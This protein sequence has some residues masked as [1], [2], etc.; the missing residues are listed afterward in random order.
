MLVCGCEANEE[1]PVAPAP[2][3]I[4]SGCVEFGPETCIVEGPKQLSIWLD[5]HPATPLLVRIDGKAVA[6]TGRVIQGGVRLAVEVPRGAEAVRVETPAQTWSPEVTIAFEWRARPPID[7]LSPKELAAFAKENSGWAKLRAL[8]RLRQMSEG[9]PSGL[10][11]GEAELALARELGAVHHQARALAQRAHTFTEIAPDHRQARDALDALD[12]LTEVSPFAA[13]RWQYHNALLARR[14]GDLGAAIA[15]FEKA[16]TLSE[17]LNFGVAD[18][19]ELLANTLAELGRVEEARDLLRQLETD[20]WEKGTGCLEWLRIANNLAWGQLVLGAAGHDHDDP[21][22]LLLAALE[23]VDSCPHPRREAALLLDLALA[24]LEYGRP[25]EA[26]GWLAHVG[27]V[28]ASLRGWIEITESAAAHERRDAWSQPPLLLRP[29][30]T[31]DFELS[32]NQSV[33]RGDLLAG[34]GFDA[35]A[36]EAYLTS[37]HQLSAT[38]EQVGTNK[39]GELYLAGRSA[40]LEGLVEALLRMNRHAEASCAVRLAR[41]R[42]FARLDRNARLSVATADERVRWERNVV[43]IAK[44]RRAIA[45]EQAGLWELSEADQVQ[46]AGKLSAQTQRTQEDLD[47]AIRGLGLEPNA[48]SC[49][50]LRPPSP[51]EVIL[52]AFASRVF[53]VSESKIQVSPRVDLSSLQNLADASRITL[54]EAGSAAGRPLHLARWRHAKSLIDLAPVS[55]SLDLPPRTVS[56]KAARTALVL[57]DPHDD[58]PEARTEADAVGRIL[59]AEGWKVI[60]LRGSDATQSSLFKHAAAIDLLHYAG[61]GVHSGLSGWDSALL[62]ANDG[63]FGIHDVFTLPDVPRGV[64]L[65]GCETAASSGDTVGGGMNIGRAF[66]LAGSDWVIAADTKVADRFA[67]DVGAEVHRAAVHQ[68]G[69]TRLRAALLRLRADDPDFPWE[70]FRVI[71]P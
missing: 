31:T 7:D 3:A 38:F 5:V 11:V 6:A 69:P 61:H 16:R 23:Q 60:D 27:S 19:V 70:Q 49:A 26:Q 34:W 41:A 22:P 71:T 29:S 59:E 55:Y 66:V 62:L 36:A 50:E 24:E 21:R 25:L 18:V 12:A 14:A 28:P 53:A 57:S 33:R 2:E 45:R 10:P 32:W 64:V 65:T 48:R 63:R 30:Q 43:D 13:A 51:G 39:G 42:E 9:N 40:S 52:V 37:E 67:A 54:V 4:F 44:K 58:L 20:L 8:E 56:A 35:L 47:E 68:D 17:R 15:G 1:L 46:I